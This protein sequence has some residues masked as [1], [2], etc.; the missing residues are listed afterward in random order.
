M[1]WLAIL[2]VLVLTVLM[3]LAIGNRACRADWGNWVEDGISGLNRLFCIHYHGMPDQLMPLPQ[4]EGALLVGNHLSGLDGFLL[5]AV[6]PRPVRFLIAREEAERFGLKW[7][8]RAARVIPV[9]RSGRSEQA[10]RAALQALKEGDAVGIFPQGKIGRHG[11]LKRGVIKLAE[12]SQA[13]VFPVYLDNIE[14]EGELTAAVVKRS[15]SITVELGKP[16]HVS[17]ENSELA[18]NELSSFLVRRS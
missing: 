18:L 16:M 17:A 8:F 1:V 13:P 5:H 2:G 15:K 3:L 12:L 7:L 11:A 9:D 4:N 10:F 14:G 6:S